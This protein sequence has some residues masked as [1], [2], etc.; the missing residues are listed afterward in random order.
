MNR[1]NFFRFLGIPII[2]LPVAKLLDL[3]K[4]TPPRN[5]T[6]EIHGIRGVFG[7]ITFQCWCGHKTAVPY[8]HGDKTRVEYLEIPMRCKHTWKGYVEIPACPDRS[9]RAYWLG[10]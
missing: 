6:Y 7:H 3:P 5:G 10:A 8:V 2:A 1:R 9:L 4:L